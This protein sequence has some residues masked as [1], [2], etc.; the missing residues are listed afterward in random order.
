MPVQLVNERATEASVG[1]QMKNATMTVGTPAMIHRTSLSWAVSM[2]KRPSPC[3]GTAE[4]PA[5]S[6]I[7]PA[8]TG[9]RLL[10]TVEECFDY[11]GGGSES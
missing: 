11:C 10:V 4:A 3:V 6:A 1:S 7:G 8:G 9:A 5:P 2:L